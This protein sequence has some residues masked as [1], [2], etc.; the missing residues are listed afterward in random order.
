[1][2][3][4]ILSGV[5]IVAMGVAAAVAGAPAVGVAAAVASAPAVGVA[6]EEAGEGVAVELHP[7]ATNKARSAV[8]NSLDLSIM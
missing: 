3:K 7:V 6:G 8:A 2:A 4:S 1:L 5:L